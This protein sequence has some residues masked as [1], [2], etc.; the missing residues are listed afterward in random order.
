[1]KGHVVNI[2]K[3]KKPKRRLTLPAEN[4]AGPVKLFSRDQY[5]LTFTTNAGMK[6]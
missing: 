6:E 5:V 2:Y 4:A 3:N 1:M